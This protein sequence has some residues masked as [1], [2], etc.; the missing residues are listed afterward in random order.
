MFYNNFRYNSSVSTPSY[1]GIIQ[2]II[3]HNTI[4]YLDTT[5]YHKVFI[6]QLTS[7]ME[8]HGQKYE[9]EILKINL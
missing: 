5:L 7:M 6:V 1:I 2:L 9:E 8:I 4:G 3:Q